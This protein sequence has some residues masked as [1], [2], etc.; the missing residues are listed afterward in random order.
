MDYL[1]VRNWERYQHYR[2]RNPPWIKLYRDLLTSRDWVA[3]NDASRVLVITSMLLAS[4]TD[5]GDGIFPA[6]PEFVQRVAFLNAPPDFGPLIK[7]GFLKPCDED[8][9]LIPV[10]EEEIVPEKPKKE[11]ASSRF[12]PPSVE[13]VKLYARERSLAVDPERFVDFYES[14][15]WFVGKN[16]MR[17]WRAAVRNWGK[18]KTVAKVPGKDQ[19]GW[20]EEEK[21]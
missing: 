9:E 16:K 15:G 19:F 21:S 1:R 12:S 3:M 17:D 7:S 4:S 2:D 20:D 5:C 13:E 14:K 10:E 8:G 6:D 18:G 11:P